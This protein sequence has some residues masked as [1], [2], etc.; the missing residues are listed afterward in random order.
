MEKRKRKI[1]LTFEKAVEWYRKGGELREVALQAFDETELNPRP[2]SWEEFCKFYP[3]QR[4]EVVFMPN[5]VLKLCGDCVGWDR[6]TLGDRSICPSM[7]SAE[8]H[9]AMMQLEQLRDC[10]R[11]NDIPDFTD[12]TQTKYS[13]RL[14]NN[15]LSIV[16]V[17]GHQHSFLS[18][19]DYEMT[20]EFLRCFK[21]LIEIAKY[22]I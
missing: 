18:F 20:K 7:K 2:E 22:L 19:T 10:W 4:N 16:R 3:V 13:I 12:S 14:I 15:E 5:S 1:T 9:R 6:D 21:P 11:K 8:A 17:S